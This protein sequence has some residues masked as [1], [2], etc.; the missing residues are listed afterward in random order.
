MQQFNKHWIQKRRSSMSSAVYFGTMG[1]V[2]NVERKQRLRRF[3]HLFSGFLILINGLNHYDGG[4]DMWP[5]FMVAG[6][7]FILLA[8]FHVPLS[9]RWPGIDGVFFLIEALVSF[10]IMIEFFTAGK[11]GLPYMYLIAGIA[12]VCAA[13]I[14]ARKRKQVK[15]PLP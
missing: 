13:W 12:Q 6:S 8:V 11:R 1:N 3:A 2:M 9:R 15:L 7:M 14:T 4:L 5:A 10:L